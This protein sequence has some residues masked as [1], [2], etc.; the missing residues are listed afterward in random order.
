MAVLLRLPSQ[1]QHKPAS[2][3]PNTMPDEHIAPTTH[4]MN[5][6]DESGGAQF[7]ACL[8]FLPSVDLHISN[9]EIFIEC[10]MDAYYPFISM[11]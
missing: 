7:I 2:M 9:T 10:H 4:E 8:A 1:L 11:S 6:A 5:E 3:L